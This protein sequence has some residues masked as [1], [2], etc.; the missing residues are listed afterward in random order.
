LYGSV[1]L[2]SIERYGVCY[3][4]HDSDFFRYRE[5][6]DAAIVSTELKGRILINPLSPR[7]S[8]M[9]NSSLLRHFKEASV[10]DPIRLEKE[11]HAFLVDSDIDRANDEAI[12]Q[13]LRGKYKS[14]KI[15]IVTMHFLSG[16]MIF[17]TIE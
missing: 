1:Y 11:G 17:E 8:Q 13:Y 15:A 10:V 9:M 4:F 12:L 3:F 5:V 16:T 7:Y 14:D 6:L 2:Q